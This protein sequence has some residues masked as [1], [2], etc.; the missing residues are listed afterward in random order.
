MVARAGTPTSHSKESAV[1]VNLN[2]DGSKLKAFRMNLKIV[3]RCTFTLLLI[4]SISDLSFAQTM[5]IDPATRDDSS[6]KLPFN[7][8]NNWAQHPNLSRPVAWHT[9]SGAGSFEFEATVEKST[10]RVRLNNFP[11][12]PCYTLLIEGK[13]V[14]HFDDWPKFWQ[15]P[16]FPKKADGQG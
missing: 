8:A 3:V 2:I 5:T 10:W 12:E 1:P 14:I 7:V 13:E 15:R 9:Y 6:Y 16:P 4:F 11:D